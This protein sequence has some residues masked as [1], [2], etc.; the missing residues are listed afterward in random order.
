MYSLKTLFT[1]LIIG[2]FIG[3]IAAGWKPGASTVIWPMVY[4]VGGSLAI[5]AWLI[6]STVFQ[7]LH[8]ASYRVSIIDR[9]VFDSV[10]FLWGTLVGA[11]AGYTIFTMFAC[12]HA[13]EGLASCSA[14]IMPSTWGMAFA[15]GAICGAIGSIFLE[16]GRYVRR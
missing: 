2:P 1:F 13:L 4:V 12:G 11:S 5:A 14:K 10:P 3:G 7:L 9:I 16:D 6:Y 15:P 8:E